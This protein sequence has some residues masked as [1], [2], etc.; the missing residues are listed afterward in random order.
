ME[1]WERF[2]S[3]KQRGEWVELQFMAQATKR[4]FAVC[5][6]WG[7]TRAYDVGIEHGPNFL[8]VKVKST[9]YRTGAGYYCQFLPNHRKKQDYTLQ[10]LDLLAAYVIPVDS[11]YLIPAALLLRPRR[12]SGV[13]L[14]PVVP[15]AKKASYATNATAKPGTSSPKAAAN[16]PAMSNDSWGCGPALSKV[17]AALDHI[18][19]VG[20]PE[21][22]Y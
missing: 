14:S 5:K 9:S 1:Y 10:Q 22:N 7:D 6:P 2:K 16:S 20:T 12:K 19:P 17:E 8:R 15:P 11:W 3:M 21:A 4:R 18:G 13:V